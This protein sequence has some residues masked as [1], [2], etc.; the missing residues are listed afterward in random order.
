MAFEPDKLTGLGQAELEW[1]EPHRSEALDRPT[2]PPTVVVIH[3]GG[4]V[5][6]TP[7][8]MNGVCRLLQRYGCRV[9]NASYRLMS[10]APYPAA[11]EDVLAAV[12]SAET[13][14]DAENT[15]GLPDGS[16]G[17]PLV[18]LG[19]SAGGF[20][21]M[22]AAFLLGHSRVA[23]VISLSGP[24]GFYPELVKHGHGIDNSADPTLL[25]PPLAL[26]NR[27]S[28]PLLA[29]HGDPDTLVP[30]SESEQIMTRM[31]ELGRPCELE[32]FANDSSG[33]GLW[34]DDDWPEPELKPAIGR[35]VI[36]FIL[37][38]APPEQA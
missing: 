8:R 18:L 31:R 19:A 33:H 6:L 4:L 32:R 1:W 26:A 5:S 9:A 27:N 35:R 16:K 14:I 20:L 10:N 23:A 3:G 29:I 28:P 22:T 11:L 21:A 12:R 30:F 24:S 15:A 13:R 34:V 36:D 2:R 37:R 17:S 38:F 25:N 7:P